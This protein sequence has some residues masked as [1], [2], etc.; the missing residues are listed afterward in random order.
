MDAMDRLNQEE[1]EQLAKQQVR[2][3]K[4]KM[5]YHN[6]APP[7]LFIRLIRDTVCLLCNISCVRYIHA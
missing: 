7:T 1:L 2:P 5:L 3:D 6:Y 4:G